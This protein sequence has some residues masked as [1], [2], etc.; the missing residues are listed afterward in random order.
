MTK[1]IV[2]DPIYRRRRLDVEIIEL[3]VRDARR[4]A[5]SNHFALRTLLSPE[6]SLR[7]GFASGSSASGRAARKGDQ[8]L[9][10]L[11]EFWHRSSP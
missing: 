6:S 4:W 8:F 10:S 9:F 1:P 2:R 7:A 11:R 5:A 3:C